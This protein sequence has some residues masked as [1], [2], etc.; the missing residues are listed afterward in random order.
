VREVRE[1]V[2]GPFDVIVIGA[3]HAGC[4]AALAS[5]RMGRRTLVLTLDVDKVALM[6]C[7]PAIGGLAKG[8]LVREI[9]ALGGEMGRAIDETGI[10]FRML[11]MRKGPAV[12]SP[13]AQA[14]KRLYAER[15][16]RALENE[17]GLSLHA[18]EVIDIPMERGRVTGVRGASG[19]FYAARAVILTTGTFLCGLVHV[20][21]EN[22]PAGRRDEPP[23]NSLSAVLRR[24][25]LEVGR[26]KTGTPP[27]IHRDSI[28]A[29]ACDVQPV[30]PEPCRFSYRSVSVATQPQIECLL[31]YTNEITHEILRE[32][33]PRS[34]LYAGVI[35]GVGPRYCPSVE[36]KIVRFPDKSRHQVF[37]EP[38]GLETDSIYC[39]G[40][41]TSIPKADQE[42]MVR[43]IAGLEHARILQYGYAVEYDYVNPICLTPE[44]RVRDVEGLYLAGQV[45]GTS[46]YEEAAAQGLM[47]GINASRYV[48]AESPFVLGRD[49]AYIGVL[50][51][52][53]VT[54]GTRE[55]YRMFTSRAEYRLLLRQDNAD[56]RLSRHGHALGLIDAESIRRLERKEA[57]IRAVVERLERTFAGGTSLARIL[58]RPEVSFEAL[59]AEHPTVAAF[60]LDDECREQVEIEVKYA[61]YIERQH[62]DVER[63]RAMEDAA[64]PPGLDFAEVPTLR[65]EAVEKLT[66]IGPATLG[67]AS[68]ISGVSPA[69]V[70]ALIVWLTFRRRQQA[71]GA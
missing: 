32:A 14:D 18:D 36:D 61:G 19:R 2:E 42:R 23:S 13:R 65:R 8:Q 52:D 54:L 28:D 39:N 63:S 24:L 71:R 69:D 11:N 56:R 68:R 30:D 57:T 46:G 62:A 55:P 49:E 44:L 1:D 17:P 50:I 40:I 22:Y 48:A 12:R 43:S 58:R 20:G 47:A 16:R 25:R 59:E 38:E 29:D 37:L 10:Q 41:S 35:R 6:P 34:P 70:S 7:N 60:R 27:R 33:L 9:D 5:A 31:T 51:D 64:I 45:N 53:L 4:E 67:Q 21:E 66:A 26:L 15:M 3:G